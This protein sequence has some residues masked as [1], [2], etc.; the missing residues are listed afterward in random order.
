MS[1]AEEI[2]DR[3]VDGPEGDMTITEA[4]I[5]AIDMTLHDP[6]AIMVK[7]DHAIKTRPGF[8]VA[9]TDAPDG[10]LRIRWRTR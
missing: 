5:R 9:I 3:I 1:A 7:L 10:G 4:E 2:F 8:Q 6:A